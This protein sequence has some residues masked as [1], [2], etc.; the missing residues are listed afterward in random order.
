MMVLLCTGGIGSG[1]SFVVSILQAMGCPAYDCD[2]R[3]KALYDEDPALLQEVVALTG[4]EVLTPERRLDRK[5]LAARLFVDPAL[6][7]QIEALVHPAV[8]RDF[9]RWKAVLPTQTASVV[10]AAPISQTDAPNAQRE[11]LAVL[12]SAIML[13]H[14]QYQPLY[15]KVLVV[16][17]PEE[18]RIARVMARDGASR[19]GVLQRMA[20][21]WPEERRRAAADYIIENDGEQPLL[22]QLTRILSQLQYGKD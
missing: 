9:E 3:A 14:P 8:I 5:A 6:R 15:D 13:E 20:S 18:V 2:A 12:E 19:E 1:K 11:S 21:Q 10:G 7:T 16:S 22:P 17:A 4:R